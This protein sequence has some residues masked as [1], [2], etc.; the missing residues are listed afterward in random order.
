MLVVTFNHIRD[1]M[2]EQTDFDGINSLFTDEDTKRYFYVY[3]S[4]YQNNE[5]V[6]Y[7]INN[8]V[9]SKEYLPTFYRVYQLY[10]HGCLAKIERGQELSTWDVNELEMI[11]ARIEGAICKMIILNCQINPP[12]EFR[13]EPREIVDWMKT[14]DYMILQNDELHGRTSEYEQQT[15]D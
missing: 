1:M 11:S 2:Y 8:K 10:Y 7:D 9:V 4:R 3:Q 6:Q 12:E 5:Q 14:R 15:W 13:C